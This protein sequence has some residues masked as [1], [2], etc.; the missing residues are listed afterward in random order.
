MRGR[1]QPLDA[2]V[3]TPDGLRPIGELRVGDLVI[4]SDGAPT[5]VLGVYPQGGKDGLP[6]HHPGRRVDARL[7]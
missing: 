5:P 4:G 1:A 7:R 2:E 3:L 6:G